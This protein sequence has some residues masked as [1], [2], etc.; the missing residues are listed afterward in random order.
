MGSDVPTLKSD[1]LVL[2]PITAD[3]AAALHRISN[4]PVVCRFL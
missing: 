1:R 4:E 2:R 3:D